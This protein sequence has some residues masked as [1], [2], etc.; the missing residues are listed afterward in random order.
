M[1]R[2]EARGDISGEPR[3]IL[4]ATMA[5]P[6]PPNNGQRM[7]NWGL[8]HAM[9]DEGHR[10]SLL[11]FA[12]P[13]EMSQDLT[14]LREICEDV[15][16]APSPSTPGRG[17][18]A[19]WARLRALF[20][21]LP[22]GA[23]RYHSPAMKSALLELTGGRQYDAVICDNIYQ[24]R[25]LP[26][27]VADRVLLNKHDFTFVIVGRLLS[28]TYNPLKLA[29]GWVEYR[30]LRRWELYVCSRVTCVL[31]CSE[32]DRSILSAA[33]P[34]VPA[35]VVPNVIDVASYQPRD[36]D[37]GQTVLFFGAMDYHANEDAVEFFISRILPEVRRTNPGTRF[38]VAGRNPSNSLLRRYAGV[39]GVE[40]TGTVADMQAV[41]A[42][43]TVCV[44]PLRIGSGTR[45]KILEAAAM[46]KPV[47]ST[48]LGAEG[49]NMEGG[50]EILLTD[51]PRE[52]A[53]AVGELLSDP[54]RRRA[55]GEAARAKVKEEYSLAALRGSL[56]EALRELRTDAP[57]ASPERALRLARERAQA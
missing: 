17:W 48:R 56:R 37:D 46:G 26:S 39:P 34:N 12:E 24:Y 54:Q 43:A 1:P 45:L 32:V 29:Y 53:R 25:N 27:S 6:F 22:Y 16:L 13:H 18:K 44:V 2:R 8:L 42:R 51:E 52:F 30:K 7:R 33:L 19:Y 50:H 41:I 28:E 20:S 15:R 36:D 49:L 3:R 9:A 11:S 35:V 21:P 31:V 47:V 40:I 57:A 5:L 10:V 23:I 38:V 4:F 55:L 14:P